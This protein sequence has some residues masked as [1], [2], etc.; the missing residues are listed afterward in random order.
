MRPDPAKLHRLTRLSRV[1]EVAR[2]SALRNASEA[3]GACDAADALAARSDALL[4]GCANPAGTA[5]GADLLEARS[6]R[7]ALQQLCRDAAGHAEEAREHDHAMRSEFAQKDHQHTLVAERLTQAKRAARR[8]G[9]YMP[10]PGNP[11]L[12]RHLNRQGDERTSP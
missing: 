9:D 11:K 12:A 6:Y 10:A 4:N 2:I 5:E 8:N 1:R 7:E 3:R